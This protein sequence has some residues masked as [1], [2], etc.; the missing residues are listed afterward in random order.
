MRGH[1]ALVV[2]LAALAFSTLAFSQ[3]K[4][5]SSPADV[6]AQTPARTPNS[7]DATRALPEG[8]VP[9]APQSISLGGTSLRLGLPKQ[10]VINLLAED[11][12]LTKI[13]E[14]DNWMV[15]SKGASRTA[16]GQVIFDKSGKLFLAVRKLTNG[17][18]DSFAV[19]QT[20]HAALEEMTKELGEM[21]LVDPRTNHQPGSDA[22]TINFVCGIGSDSSMKQLVVEMTET[23]SGQYQGK[24]IDISELLQYA[25]G[26][27]K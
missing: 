23:Y 11:Y 13:G 8:R 7:G 18:E 2:V 21:C 1:I 17:D 3:D 16:L 25:P 19:M 12:K 24:M 4:G 5:A 22:S 14:D 10:T 9:A 20:L 26:S 15:E 27:H 6:P